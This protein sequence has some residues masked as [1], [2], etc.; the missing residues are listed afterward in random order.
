M[1]KDILLRK[2]VIPIAIQG[3]KR[4]CHNPLFLYKKHFCPKCG[5]KLHVI[6]IEKIVDS[7]SPE[8]KKYD[9]SFGNGFMVGEVKFIRT[10]FLCKKCKKKY[11]VDAVKRHGF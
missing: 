2:G 1:K 8:A 5:S 6:K 3:V 7:A 11:S 10:A 4:E 9:F